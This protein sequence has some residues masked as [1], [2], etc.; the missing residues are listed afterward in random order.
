MGVAPVVDSGVSLEMTEG[1]L[2]C[3]SALTAEEGTKFGLA[4]L[5][6]SAV[7]ILSALCELSAGN[8]QLG[9]RGE[10]HMGAPD[11][12]SEPVHP[13]PMPVDLASN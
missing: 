13:P 6:L 4:I 10:K 3:C 11:S 2:D 9:Q 8:D 1:S 12:T 5:E 7:V